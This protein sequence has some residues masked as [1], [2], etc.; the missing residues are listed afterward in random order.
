MVL[1]WAMVVVV[2]VNSVLRERTRTDICPVSTK[3]CSLTG[4]YMASH[5]PCVEQISSS[6][7]LI[8]GCSEDIFELWL[9]RKEINRAL[10]AHKIKCHVC[11]QPNEP[12]CPSTGG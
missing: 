4:G 5:I 6:E 2:S 7:Y 10:I 12:Y 1:T 3:C 11:N 9:H 8:T